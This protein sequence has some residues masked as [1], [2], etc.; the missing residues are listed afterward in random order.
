[1]CLNKQ[2]SLPWQA[3]TIHKLQLLIFYNIGH[4]SN[5]WAQDRTRLSMRRH[6]IQHNDTYHND[7]QHSDTQNKDIQHNDTQ[8]KGII[9]DTQHK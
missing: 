2:E 9:C 1:M 7:I 3:S 5:P 6:D 8:N 4:S